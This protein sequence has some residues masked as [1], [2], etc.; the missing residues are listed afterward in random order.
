MSTA[1]TRSNTTERE[2]LAHRFA[3]VLCVNTDLDRSLV[4][5]QAN[6][7]EPFYNW[8]KYKEGFSSR[9]V[10]YLLDK[11]TDR[12]GVLLDP[13]AGAGAAL[14]ASREMGWN[15]V[16]VELLP[17]GFFAML[18]RQNIETMDPV[19]LADVV[20]HVG[21]LTFEDYYDPEFALR[22]LRITNGAFGRAKERQIAGWLA[23]CA[24]HVKNP[25]VRK[26]FEFACFSCLEEISYTRKD[27]QYLRWD[28]RSHRTRG[29]TGFK[30]ATILSLR[31]ALNKKLGQIVR[32]LDG[33]KRL[34][35]GKDRKVPSL[36]IRRGSCLEM[37]PQLPEESV[38]V[39]LTSPPYC[40]RYDYTRTYAL[41]LA[42]LGYGEEGVKQLRQAM[43]SCTVENRA[44]AEQLKTMYGENGATNAFDIVDRTFHD[45]SA[46]AEVLT[47]LD[48]KRSDRQL[49]NSNV[50]RMVRNYFYEMCFVVYELARL[51]RPGGKV[52][53]VNDNVRYAGE[54][55][56]VDLV[57]ADFAEAFG[58]HVR[59]IWVLPRG[60]GN[61]SQ[62][63]GNHGRRELRKCVYVWEKKGQAGAAKRVRRDPL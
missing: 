26:V 41:E 45:Q 1:V 31:D 28:A 9:L 52:I 29:S 58:L 42:F 36:D 3:D 33:S 2:Q 46:L 20:E 55:I 4:S 51:V 24:K 32:D 47:V 27:G 15:A 60:K 57:L 11:F 34:L 22:H 6:K 50:P 56:P 30:K 8:F 38:D 18:A 43:L 49:N 48:L 61:S 17:V 12:P 39:V 62:Q 59:H 35:R 16:G 14:F 19:A 37:L 54:E 13:F 53:M 23:Y 7:K 21:N 10:H 40:N 63:M 25:R 44:K 5:F